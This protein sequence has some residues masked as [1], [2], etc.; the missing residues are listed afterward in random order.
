MTSR[1][2]GSVIVLKGIVAALAG[3]NPDGDLM[4]GSGLKGF[5]LSDSGQRPAIVS[6]LSSEA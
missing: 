6:I 4:S 5:G 1:V 3:E 2:G